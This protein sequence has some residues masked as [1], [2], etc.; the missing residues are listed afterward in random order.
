MEPQALVRS[1]G[2]DA[3]LAKVLDDFELAGRGRSLHGRRDPRTDVTHDDP[4]STAKI[5]LARLNEF[6]D[7]YTRLDKMEG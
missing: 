7:Y 6:S 1:R 3:R 5:A 2:L 4:V